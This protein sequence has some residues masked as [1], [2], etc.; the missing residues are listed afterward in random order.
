MGRRAVDDLEAIEWGMD[1][2]SNDMDSS[3]MDTECQ[4]DY[5]P[6]HAC[7]H[8]CERAR[9]LILPTVRGNDA[10]ASPR[11]QR[12]AMLSHVPVH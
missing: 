6:G 11:C 12:A 8:H 1:A 5:W 4:M 10:V 7:R 9:P 3:V 2:D